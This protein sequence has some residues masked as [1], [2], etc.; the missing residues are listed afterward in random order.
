M[1]LITNDTLIFVFWVASD[2][3]YW[4]IPIYIYIYI[5]DK[6]KDI[7]SGGG[8]ITPWWNYQSTCKQNDWYYPL[9]IQ[10]PL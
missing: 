6:I 1:S 7:F 10:I 9:S 3:L 5:L 4:I 2:A 8:Q